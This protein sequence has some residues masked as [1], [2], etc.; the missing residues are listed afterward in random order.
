MLASSGESAISWIGSI[1]AFLLLLVGSA[2]GP[3]YDAGYFRELIIAG[4]AFMVIGHML[5]SL[6]HNY[7]QVFLAQGV[8]IGLGPGM[9]FVPSVAILS[10]YFRKRIALSVGV[11]AAGSSLGGVIYPIVLHR[12]LRQVGFGWAVRTLGFIALATLVV[13]NVVMRMRVLPKGRRAFLDLTAFRS[14]EY[15]LFVGASFIGFMGLYMIFFYISGF[16]IAD[17]LTDENLAFYLLSILNAASTFGRLI[18]NMIA[19]IIGPYNVFVPAATLSGV[20]TLCTIAVTSKGGV[21]AIAASYGFVS[22]A[23]VS[24]PP[25]IMIKITPDP[26]VIGTRMGMC[27]GIISIGMLIGPPVGG[28]ILASAGFDGVWIYG[29]VLMISGGMITIASRIAFAG[30][31]PF[32]KV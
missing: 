11:A 30:W 28:Q 31:K 20:V 23:F 21:V 3:L 9:L 6:C 12:L 10:Q 7:W 16:A 5:L 24:V 17:R 8:C 18:P 26:S 1:Q 13:P 32:L 27:F 29:G 19:D 14:P 22:G 15:V 4:S 2:T 25:T